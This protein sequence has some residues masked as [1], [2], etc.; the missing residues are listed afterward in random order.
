MSVFELVPLFTAPLFGILAPAD[1]QF[2]QYLARYLLFI[3]LVLALKVLAQYAEYYFWDRIGSKQNLASRILPILGFMI[4]AGIA[5]TLLTLLRIRLDQISFILLLAILIVEAL[6]T[7]ARRKGYTELELLLYFIAA[8]GVGFFT[9]HLTLMR[10]HW[11][12]GLAAMSIASMVTAAK[13][14]KSISKERIRTWIALI[15]FGPTAIAALCYLGA[16]PK[17][18]ILVMLIL[19]LA[20]PFLGLLTQSVESMSLPARFLQ[21]STGI[22]A[23][24]VVILLILSA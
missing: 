23:L 4:G 17:S 19:L 24:F 2:P 1:E 12:A 22:S 7:P 5:L 6:R 9:I 3:A 20:R 21:Q 8:S 13:L 16:L 15:L 14:A 11:E 10:W 18:Y